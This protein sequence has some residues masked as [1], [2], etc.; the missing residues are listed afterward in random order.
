MSAITCHSD[1]V[2][3]LLITL[4]GIAVYACTSR[5]SDILARSREC[6]DISR[7]DE[8]I[9]QA[10]RFGRIPHTAASVESSFRNV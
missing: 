4:I 8:S 2:K 5:A 7:T 3:F 1:M 6:D 9:R 10:L